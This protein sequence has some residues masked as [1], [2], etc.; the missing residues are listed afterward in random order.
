[1]TP[2]FNLVKYTEAPLCQECKFRY[3]NGEIRDVYGKVEKWCKKRTFGN[4][5]KESGRCGNYRRE[6]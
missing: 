2:Q 6:L 4:E 1:M 5:A 3:A